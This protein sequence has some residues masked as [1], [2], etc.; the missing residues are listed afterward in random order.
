MSTSKHK[1]DLNLLLDTHMKSTKARL[2]EYAYAFEQRINELRRSFAA[3]VE[4]DEA[5]RTSGRFT[6][7]GERAERRL[8][9][10]AFRDEKIRVMRAD[11]VGKLEARL[12]ETR[13][14]ALRPKAQPTEPIL[15]LLKEGRLRELREHLRTLDPLMLQAR[16]RQAVEDGANTDLLEALEGAPAGFPLAPAELVQQTRERIAEKNH[17]ELGELAQ[18]RDAYSYALG[19]VEQTLLAASGLNPAELDADPTPR[20]ADARRPLLG[21]T[22][23]PVPPA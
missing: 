3:Y 22:G 12:A 10:R 15:Q 9:A 5:I 1:N 14:A 8:A 19:A 4:K 23:Q 2:P 16:I 11:T 7:D 17:P 13:A 6:S 20:A 18:L 21:S